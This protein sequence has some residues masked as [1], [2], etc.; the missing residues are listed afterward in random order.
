MSRRGVLGTGLYWSYPLDAS[1]SNQ[2][3]VR[4]DGAEDV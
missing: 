4:G 1:R 2:K 3:F